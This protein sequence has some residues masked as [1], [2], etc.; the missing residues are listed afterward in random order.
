MSENIKDFMRKFIMNDLIKLLTTLLSE[1]SYHE[2]SDILNVSQGT[3][4]RWVQNNSV[5]P[6]YCFEL[7]KMSGIPL[8]FLAKKR[9][10]FLLPLLRPSGVILN[11]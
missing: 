10:N 1:K 2:I 7:M 5:P 3:V 11:F 9:I 8:N 6:L 4:K